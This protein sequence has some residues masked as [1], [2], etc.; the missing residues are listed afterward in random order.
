MTIE[1]K[2]SIEKLMKKKIL[3][4]VGLMSGTS[5]DGVDVTVN[6]IGRDYFKLIAFDTF[7]Y[8]ATLRKAIFTLFQQQTAKL[9]D[10][11]HYILIK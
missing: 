1:K 8:P 6:D 7:A 2:Q 5:V 10:I 9:D 3:R 11:C 4:V